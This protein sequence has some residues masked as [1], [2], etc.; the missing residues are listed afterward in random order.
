MP[1]DTLTPHEFVSNWRDRKLTE[2]ESSQT[3]F[4]QLCKLLGVAAPYDNPAD[5]N[6]YRFDAI[7][8]TGGSHAY[9]A[10][11][12]GRAPKKPKS[13]GSETSP[14]F[15]SELENPRT[16]SVGLPL[17][18]TDTPQLE[19]PRI[20]SAKG[21]GFADVWKRGCF[22]WEY[23][24]Q[25][26][27]DRNAAYEQLKQYRDSLENP[28]LLI[29]CDIDCFDIY[30]N[31]TGYPTE[32]HH[33]TL[34]D[35]ANPSEE[36]TTQRGIAPINVLRKIF[37]PV[38][39]AAFFKPKKS[40]NAITEERASEI[41]KLADQIRD[42][43]AKDGSKPDP[44][45]VA[46]F[47]MQI[48]FAFYAEDAGLLHPGLVTEL[49][50]NNAA[51]PDRFTAQIRQL[52]EKMEKGGDFGPYPVDHFNGG[53][54]KDVAKQRIPQ[55]ASPEIGKLAIIAKDDWT[56]IEPSILGTL[57]E[58]AL[59]PDK[60][61]QIGAHYTSRD[62]IMLIVGPVVMDPLRREWEQTKA[63]INDLLLKR[64]KAKGPEQHKRLQQEIERDLRT[65]HDRLC[66][67]S[68]LDPACGSGN[69][70]YVTIQCLLDL[71]R[72]AIAFASIDIKSDGPGMKLEPRV[73]PTQL[74]GIEINELAAELA[75]ISIWIGYLKWMREN[76]L[77]KSE[78]PI[79]DALDTIETRDAILDRTDPA[80]PIPAKWPKSDFIV[81]NPP[82]LGTKMLRGGLG[83]EYVKALFGTFKDRIP[84]FSDLCCYWFELARDAITRKP[85]TR[86]G[87]LATQ[88][89]RN[90]EARTVLERIKETGDIFMAWSDR[91]WLLDGAA[92]RIAV[93]GFDSGRQTDRTLD[94][95]PEDNINA[96]LTS[97]TNVG[98]SRR[99]P[100]NVSIG[101]VADVKSGAFDVD[102]L[103]AARWLALPNPNRRPNSDVLLPWFNGLDITRRNRAM[104]I[105]DFGND[106]PQ[107]DASQYEQPFGH[108]VTHVKP[109]RS[110]V[111]RDKYRNKWWIHAEPCENMRRATRALPRYIGTPVLTKHR[112]FAWLDA[113]SLPDHQLVVFARADDY[114]F[115]VL[116]STVHEVWSLKQ[117]TQQEDRPRYTPT[118]TFETFPLPWPPGKEP[119]DPKV[120]HHALWNAIGDAAK[121]LNDLR[122][123]WLN[124]PEWIAQIEKQVAIKYR[125]ELAAVPD[126][127]R[128]LVRRSAVMA[129]AAKHKDLKLRTLTN[130][131]NQRPAWLRIAHEKLDRTVL[132]AYKAVDPS[133]GWDSEWAAA[134]EPFGAGEITIRTKGTKTNPADSPEAVAAKNAA[135]AK[136]EAIDAKILAALLRLNHERAAAIPSKPKAQ[137]STAPK[138]KSRRAK[139]SNAPKQVKSAKPPKPAKTKT[140]PRLAKAAKS[141]M[142]PQPSKPTTTKGPRA[143]RAK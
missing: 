110:K 11:K 97:G 73:K 120:K 17:S 78:R 29:V 26:H 122:E 74:H 121:Q 52:F 95:R 38:E 75:R 15:T 90:G 8:A 71:E 51:K 13:R 140:S 141:A 32:H 57:F 112:L 48:I 82:F 68:I 41:A 44:Y 88:A 24:R 136:R 93:V 67:V 113:D 55:L 124:P 126:D 42:R 9:A 139:P 111:K 53:L 117:G 40:V 89:I 116:H 59:N 133:G 131:Y 18:N 107:T 58:R 99:L 77:M 4:A 119:T 102:W 20:I 22:C 66:S 21:R 47:L 60:R 130:L 19:L 46:H 132:A 30:T 87:L 61:A 56:A 36:W 127:V 118:S 34:E 27:A 33:F 92:V 23:K 85:D 103:H 138:S 63:R 98:D 81:G 123:A 142:K 70:L 37:D 2:R 137:G 105:V 94:G 129:E 7:T 64:A 12:S 128:P 5:D 125:E 39:I 100:E 109:E 14:L 31:F 104:W 49:V 80:K 84:G 106:M 143:S 54:F 45:D 25:G 135:I 114:F 35:L 10:A 3:H 134:Y 65:F 1:T 69:F 91:A 101:F 6:D 28:P 72:E 108:V 62:D 86:V 115:G 50:Q 16:E 79:L 96:D 83:D 43:K 76:G